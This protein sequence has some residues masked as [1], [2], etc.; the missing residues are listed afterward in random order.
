MDDIITVSIKASAEDKSIS[1]KMEGDQ[2]TIAKFFSGIVPD[3]IKNGA[4]ILNDNVRYWRF[5]NQIKIIEK[6]QKLIEDSKLEKKFIPLKVLAPIIEHSSLEE[7]PTV[8]EKWANMLANAATGKQEVSPNYAAILNELSSIEVFILD[9]I[10]NNASQ[11]TDYKKRKLIQ[12]DKLQL[13]NLLKI[14]EKK[15]DLIVENLFR[16]NLLQTP[17]SRGASMGNYPLALRTNEIFEFTTLG[18]EFVK[19]CRWELI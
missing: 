8:Q 11:E 3:A 1:A 10:Y 19:A 9:K 18:Y 2:E 14:D 15:S 12:F 16:L 13:K 17:G 4:G 6:T 7:D 5:S